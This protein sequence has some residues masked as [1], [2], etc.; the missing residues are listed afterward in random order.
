MTLLGDVL[1]GG[2]VGQELVVLEH[3]ADLTTQERNLAVAQVREVLAGDVDVTRRGL[4]LADDGLDERRLARAGMA[5]KE[6]E[7]AGHDVERDVVQS[8]PV[9]LG[10]I[11]QRH[12]AHRD[13]GRHVT[14]A[15]TLLGSGHTARGPGS[16]LSRRGGSGASEVVC[17][18]L[19]PITWADRMCQKNAC[20]LARIKAH[21][22]GIVSNHDK[23][24]M[25]KG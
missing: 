25:E 23:T 22:L 7:V 18:L 9:R 8:R 14:V 3:A 11:H 4:E 19:T 12:M 16:G 17:H 10:G 2:A 5:D 20:L 24:G 15:G 13:G 6:D 1:V 21:V